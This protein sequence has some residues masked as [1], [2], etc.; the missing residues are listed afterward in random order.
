[1]LTRE[2]NGIRK[3]RVLCASN[4]PLP[5]SFVALPPPYPHEPSTFTAAS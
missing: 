3:P 4:Y 5:Q 1:M 2:K